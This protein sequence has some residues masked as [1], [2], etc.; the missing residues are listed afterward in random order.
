ML[1]P[2]A[3]KQQIWAR[4]G[5]G[6]GGAGAGGPERLLI[7][8]GRV[9]T[10]TRR[11]GI[12]D[13]GESQPRALRLKPFR[14][15]AIAI[16]NVEFGAFVEATGYVTPAGR[17]G[18]S[19]VFQAEVPE[20]LGPTQGVAGVSW[21]RKVDGATWRDVN[22]PGAREEAWH[23]DHPVVHVS[24]QD[25]RA[26]AVWAG[27]RLPSE[28]EWEHA[29]RGGLG[30]VA[31][32]WGEEEPDD[33]SHL[34][35]NIWQGRFT[36]DN[37]GADDYLTTAPVRAFAPNGYGLCNVVG[38]VWEWTA[39]AYRIPSLKRDVR[40]RHKVC[41]DTGPQKAVRFCATGAIATATG[42]PLGRATHRIVRPRIRVSV[43]SG[44]LE[45]PGRND[46]H[47][48]WQSQRSDETK[49]TKAVVN[50][51]VGSPIQPSDGRL[52]GLIAV[53]SLARF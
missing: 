5:G 3:R 25:A 26:H 49:E 4:V 44:Q 20:R 36:E 34:P 6:A 53:R 41:G 35:C 33:V 50:V 31:F 8:G 14:I 12:P 7:P 17:F 47:R 43:L 22:G 32:P 21:W 37:T 46:W 29:A 1:L 27:D 11:P 23:A 38:N 19:F 24:W 52:M 30:D 18:W 40:Q 39:D 42:S 51:P 15:G 16:S 2:G 10:G 45:L 28:A 48:V 9:L 13:N